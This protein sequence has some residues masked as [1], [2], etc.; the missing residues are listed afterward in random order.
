M[1]QDFSGMKIQMGISS[2]LDDTVPV[3][4]STEISM[5]THVDNCHLWI[6]EAQ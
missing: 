3:A 1:F 6:K 2:W 5:P 4:Q